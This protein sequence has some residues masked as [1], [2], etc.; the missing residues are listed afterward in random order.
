[1]S[2]PIIEVD[3]VTRSVTDSTGTLTILHDIDFTLQRRQSTAIVGASGSGKSTLLA[4][5]AGLDH[6]TSGTVWLDGEDI[7]ALDEDARAGLRA[8]KL[9]FVFQSF[10]LLGH[11]SALENVMLPLELLGRSD[12]RSKAAEMLRRV[13]LGERLNHY[14]RTLSG[15]EQQ[16][17]AL[18]RAFVVEP[19]VLLALAVGA[20][21]QAGLAALGVAVGPT[22]GVPQ[23]PQP[24]FWQVSDWAALRSGLDTARLATPVLSALA[25]FAGTAAALSALDTLLAASVVDGRLRQSRDANRELRAQGLANLAAALVGGRANSPSVQ[26]SLALV[27]AW[28]SPRRAVAGYALALL[29]LLALAPQ[30]LG[31]LPVSAIGGVLVLQGLQTVDPWLW[32]TP[33]ALRR[34]GRSTGYD[35]AQ[36]RLLLDNWGVAAT[37]VACSLLLGLAVAV[38]VGAAFSVLL[39]VRANMR[40]VVRVLHRGDSRRSLKVRSPD[41]AAALRREG[42]RIAVLELQGALFFGTADSLRDAL[43]ALAPEVD[44]AVLDLYLVGE[45]DATGARILL[46]LADEWARRGKSLVAS[47]W[48]AG[49]ARRGVVEAIARSNRLPLLTFVDDSDQALQRAEDALL[50]GCAL[51][52]EGAG[53]LALADTLLA[54][55]LDAADLATLAGQMQTL[56]FRQGQRLFAAGDVADALYVSLRGHIGVHLPGQARR[57][58]SFAPGVM[59]GELAVIEHGRRSADAV[60]ESDLTVLRLSLEALD[61][62]QQQ[63]PALAAQ[64]LRNVALHLAGR[65]R[66]L[67]LEL[68]AW[69]ARSAALP[70]EGGF[71]TSQAS[72]SEPSDGV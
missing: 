35:P 48:P 21:L 43:A 40:S 41:A 34:L 27:Q 49:D 61:H 39:F 26:R 52:A 5:T 6:P 72:G 46:E 10:Q 60:A 69:V 18:A 51:A 8:R 4:L 70:G 53:T 68:Q 47:E 20:L 16:R 15:G 12:A 55:G 65:L 7:F 64:L 29:A 50:T 56:H 24:W 59:V 37:V 30:L 57:L 22:A 36:R 66:G 25:V 9:G 33:Q 32:R 45:V 19:A 17:V 71:V 14:P 54:Q 31:W 11:L 67:T 42:R 58:A 28:P 3:H 62:L 1:M 44:S 38:L 13:G 2:D 63:H 23:L